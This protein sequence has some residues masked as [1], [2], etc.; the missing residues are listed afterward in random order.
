[1]SL[2]FDRAYQLLIIPSSGDGKSISKLRVTFEIVKS[3]LSFPNLAKISIYNP[4]QNTLSLLQNKFTK[5]LFNAGYVGNLK[6]LFSGEIRNVF[7]TRADVDTIVTIYAGDGEKSWQN[8]TFNKTLSENISISNTIKEVAGSFVDLTIGEIA[9]L[10]DNASKLRGQVLSGSSKDI[11]D[12]FAKEYGFEWSIQN[13]EVVIT[14]IN[15]PL[16]TSQIALIN[17]QTGMLG[18]PTITEI[19]VDVKTLLNPELLPNRGFTIESSNANIQIGNLFFRNVNRRKAEGV[20]KIQEVTFKGDS[21][22]SQWSSQIK[23]RS[24]T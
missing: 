3:V 7:Q 20:Y 15:K 16:L 12:N 4:N 2:L 19:G 10:P 1:V 5:I 6:L 18:T 9:G 22:D 17:A 21:R 14:S 11:L 23:G 13:E 8:S 24:I